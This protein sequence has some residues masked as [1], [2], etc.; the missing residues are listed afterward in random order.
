MSLVLEMP[1]VTDLIS[2]CFTVF[3]NKKKKKYRKKMEILFFSPVQG[4]WLSVMHWFGSNNYVDND[5]R[6]SGFR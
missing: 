6:A 1:A 4:L 2:L 3:N 5:F